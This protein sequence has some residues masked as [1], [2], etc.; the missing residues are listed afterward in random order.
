MFEAFWA[1][2]ER[3]FDPAA[4]AATSSFARMDP[5]IVA[6]S[7]ASSAATSTTAPGTPATGSCERS[8][9]TTQDSA[10]SSTLD[11]K[12]STRPRRSDH[13]GDTRLQ[14]K[15]SHVDNAGLPDYCFHILIAPW[16]ALASRR[17]HTDGSSV[18]TPSPTGLQGIVDGGHQTEGPARTGPRTRLLAGD[19]VAVA[20]QAVVVVTYDADR[21]TYVFRAVAAAACTV[22]VDG[23]GIEASAL[24]V[25]VTVAAG[26]RCR[27]SAAPAEDERDDQCQDGQAPPRGL[28]LMG[29]GRLS[30]ERTHLKR[31]S[32]WPNAPGHAEGKRRARRLTDLRAISLWP[33]VFFLPT[34][35]LIGIC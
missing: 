33:D 20:I 13:R 18:C 24:V 8:I 10:S 19:S 32:R 25:R 27:R 30:T 7:S 11:A 34:V 14:R 15:S 6:G 3:V 16:L 29:G 9:A 17:T 12:F 4:R 21:T 23:V 26:A 5:Q 28:S 35:T 22:V 31:Q 1:H 2:P